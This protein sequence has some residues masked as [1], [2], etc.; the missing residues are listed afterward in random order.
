MAATGSYGPPGRLGLLK[1]EDSQQLFLVDT[2]SVYSLVP[3]SSTSSP[4]GPRIMTADKT[5]IPCWGTRTYNIRVAGHVFTWSFLLAAIA[6]PIVGAD[7]LHNFKL[8]VDLGRMQIN[9]RGGGRLRLESPKDSSTFAAIGVRTGEEM[10]LDPAS[11]SRPTVEAL[12]GSSNGHLRPKQDR[13]PAAASVTG[14]AGTADQQTSYQQILHSFP[15]VL[16][17]SKMLPDVT[18]RVQHVLETKGRPVSSRYRRLDPERLRAAKKVFAEMEQQGIIRRSKS[19]WASPLHMV[20]KQDGTWRP[21]GDF[22]R[23]NLQTRPDKY[24]CPNMADL[25]ARLHGCKVF[26]KLDLRKGYHQVPVHPRDV[27]KTAVSTPFGLWE[28][29]R[30]P[31]GLRNAGQ[32]FQRMMDEVLQGLDYCFVYLDD[33]LIASLDHVQH[34]QHLREVLQRLE[35]HGLVLNGEKC[36]LG[37]ATVDYLGHRVSAQGIRPLPERVEAVQQYPQPT[38]LKGL[39]SYLGMINFYRRFVPAAAGVLKPLTDA[40]R[41]SKRTKLQWT[42]DMQHAFK[43]SKELLAEAATLAHPSERAELV[44]AVDASNSHVGAV[45]QQMVGG[46]LQPLS[47]FSKKLD[48]AQQKYSAFDRELLACYLAIRHFRWSLEGR[49]FHVLSDHKPLSFALH[50]ISDAWSARQQRQLGFVAEYTSDIRHVAGKK[51][52]VAD[53]LSRPAV[54]S[55]VNST[56]ELPTVEALRGSGNGHLRPTQDR[57]PA[58]A[59]TTAV[60]A[61]APL[62]DVETL[63]REQR[64]CNSTTELKSRL[65]VQEVVVSGQKLWC[66]VSTGVLRPLVPTGLRHRVFDS[67]H[68]LAHP[69][70]RAT[71]RMLTSRYVWDG[72]NKDVTAWCRDCVHCARSK[73]GKVE[74]S[75][76]QPI[77]TPEKRFSHVHVD[78]VGPWPSSEGYTHLFTMIDRTSRWCEV[79]PVKSTTAKELADTFV[80]HWVAR[81]GVPEM[82]TTDQGAQFISSTWQCM[83]KKIGTKHIHTTAYHPQS[84]GIVERMHR[85]L[86]EALRARCSGSDWIEHLPWVLLGLRTAPKEEANVSAAEATYGDPLVLPGQI[87]PL[88]REMPKELPRIPNTTKSSQHEEAGVPKQLQQAELVYVKE[89]AASKPLQQKFRGPYKVLTREPKKMELQI[90]ERRE[91]VS[92]DRIKPHTGEAQAFPAK[93]PARGRPQKYSK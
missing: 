89:G 2:G 21:C 76:V 40:L 14:G 5:P 24:T 28:F 59:G 85:Q 30:M 58:V 56:V 18:H 71:R 80:Q 27:H 45:L 91:W 49:K 4:T 48:A 69:G 61:P 88:K 73:P 32:T 65:N 79:I 51:N 78:V 66:E 25:S 47:F 9:T 15:K 3:Y 17:Q 16:N 1:D 82:V 44:L 34:R 64:S 84:N 74:K 12:G 22:R 42:P 31:F 41:G 75:T 60:V 33:L 53:A 29:V 46:E 77:E 37:A 63:A 55:T 35:Q 36:V 20:P 11:P 52:V 86:K 83:C 62:V 7:F 13:P 92:V 81:F 38:T 70:V 26:S 68:Q 54:T 19:N 10:R 90:G 57:P 6:F 8:S 72:M 39:Q 87:Q 23:L 93:P 67:V 50:R 43:V